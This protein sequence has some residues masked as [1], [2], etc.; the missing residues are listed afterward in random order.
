MF[1][2][3]VIPLL[4]GCVSHSS[5]MRSTHTDEF[6][7]ELAAR[8]AALPEEPLS[9]GQCIQLAVENNYD[10]RMADL[11]VKL[12][13]LGRGI[14][15]SK[16][17]PQVTL[18]ADW[19]KWDKNLPMTDRDYSTAKLSVGVPVI[20]PSVWFMYASQKEKQ[21][22]AAAMAH[23]IK[24]SICL[25]TMV[26]YYDCMIS[27]DEVKVMEKQVKTA[28]ET[29]ERVRGLTNEGFAKE[30]EGRQAEAQL[31]AREVDLSVSKRNYIN[32]KGRLLNLIGLPP[33][34][35]YDVLQLSGDI[36]K[37]LYTGEG[38]ES[39]I[40]T[41]LAFH[42]E[43]EVADREMV[44]R[45]NELR[46]AIADF[47]PTLTGFV[48]ATWTTDDGG[49]SSN[50]SMGLNAVWNVFDGFANVSGYRA[51]KV[52]K[53][54]SQLAREQ[55]F[56]RIML[57]VVTA[58]NSVNDARETA[59]VL[60]KVFESLRLKYEDYVARQREGLI[61][62]SDALDVEAEMYMAQLNML[63][64]TY[65]ERVAWATLNMTMG[66]MEL[67]EKIDGDDDN[68]ETIN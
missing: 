13:E 38:I 22:Q 59:E 49:H 28:R 8:R 45:E 54:K 30:W 48:N 40:L 10:A 33:D 1:G 7:D 12:A 29:A 11:D 47:L 18:G 67:P 21:A 52:S 53:E 15:F 3:C 6:L 61:P 27:E 4:S 62:L 43:L 50:R 2:G 55:T 63:R 42:P 9:M 14:A 32:R 5:D 25:E 58:S 17:F 51:A 19:I 60:G 64:S 23:Y 37:P 68:F 35:S 39:L 46:K 56:L 26:T 65:Q 31:A 44:I 16:F 34:Y 36:G 66:I 41:A 20:V 24:Q 57:D